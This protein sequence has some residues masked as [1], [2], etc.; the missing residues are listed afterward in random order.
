LFK[1]LCRRF[2]PIKTSARRSIAAAHMRRITFTVQTVL[3]SLFRIDHFRK[4]PRGVT[5]LEWR[6]RMEARRYRLCLL[7]GGAGCD[8][9]S[10]ARRIRLSKCL[11]CAA[12]SGSFVVGSEPD[13]SR[14]E[15]C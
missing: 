14:G 10:A 3:M 12:L 4:V 13:A 9:N 11:I 6:T 1:K 7:F 15:R 2:Q 5:V 8:E